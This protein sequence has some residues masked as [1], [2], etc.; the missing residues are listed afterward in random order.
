MKNTII[1][2]AAAIALAV[3]A[4]AGAPVTYVAPAPAPSNLGLSGNIGLAYQSQYDFRGATDVFQQLSG[5]EFA[6]ANEFDNVVAASINADY[7]FTENF[8]IVAGAVVRT[9][10]DGGTDHNTY[11]AGLVWKQA[12]C[13]SIEFGYQYQ[14][15]RG[16]FDGLGDGD[17]DE[18]YLNLGTVCP[19]TG[20]DINLFWA[21]SLNA[22][23]EAPSGSGA[24]DLLDGDYIELSAHKSFE[25]TDWAAADITLGVSYA[26]DYWSDESDFNNWYATLAFPLKATEYLTVTPYVTYTDGLGAMENTFNTSGANSLDEG[27][28]FF[29]GVKASVNF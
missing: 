20:A 5:N 3:P 6:N 19:W 26:M 28:D 1:T 7:A 22:A 25:L 11:R 12:D 13:Y 14:D 8:S 23:W 27:D 24:Y 10:P 4:F 16:S 17:F 29:W 18:L 15:L 9:L 21:H 2:G